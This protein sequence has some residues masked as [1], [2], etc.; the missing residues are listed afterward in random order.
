MNLDNADLL[1]GEF[2]VSFNFFSWWHINAGCNV[3]YTTLSGKYGPNIIK[4]SHF[5][6]TANIQ[7]KIQLPAGIGLLISGYYRS[8]L[9]DVMGTY[10]VRYFIDLAIN[11]KIM[12]NKGKLIFKISDVLNTYRYGLDLVGVDDKGYEYNQS[13]SRKNES[14]Y[15]ILSFVYNFEGKEKQKKKRE[16]LLRKVW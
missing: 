11:K 1:G 13:N 15:F 9:P 8:K 5:A 6:Y 16:L 12:K 10:M 2:S 4:R 7:N 3:F 14:Q